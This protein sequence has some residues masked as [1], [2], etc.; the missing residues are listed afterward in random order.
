MRLTLPQLQM[1]SL[2]GEWIEFCEAVPMD[3]CQRIQ[4][5]RA[6]L[7]KLTGRDFGF[8]LREW[9]DYLVEKDD[10]FGYCWSDEHVRVMERIEEAE[11]DPDWLKAVANLR[12]AGDKG[13]YK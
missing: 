13:T 1:L 8:D 6:G 3:L 5:A 2:A 10:E 9:H 4:K 11:V 7:V 12:Q